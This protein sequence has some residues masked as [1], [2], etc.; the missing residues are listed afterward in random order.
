MN[1]YRLILTIRF[2]KQKL[3]T[4]HIYQKRLQKEGVLAL[5]HQKITKPRDQ[6]LLEVMEVTLAHN[7]RRRFIPS[8]CEPILYPLILHKSHAIVT[9]HH[10]SQIFMGGPTVNELTF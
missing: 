3:C 1:S 4:I 9:P 7:L 10:I 8:A 2:W 6:A 5:I